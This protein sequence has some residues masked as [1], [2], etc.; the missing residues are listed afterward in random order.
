MFNLFNKKIKVIKPVD[1]QIIPL[2]QVKDQVFSMKMM[3]DGLAIIPSNQI[4]VAPISGKI[5]TLIMPSAH[6]FGIKGDN[7]LELLIHIGL[8]TIKRKGVG[9]NPIKK[10]GDYIKQ[11]EAIISLEDELFYDESYDLTTMIVVTNSHKF[12]IQKSDEN[13]ILF[14]CCKK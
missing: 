1:G 11:G 10:Q 8:D 14:Y 7:G 12:N 9:F 3:G 6:A 4:I 2:E 13:D 5:E